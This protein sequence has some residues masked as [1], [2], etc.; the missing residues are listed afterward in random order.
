MP[1][2]LFIAYVPVFNGPIASDLLEFFCMCARR[3]QSACHQYT[4]AG[5]CIFG[6]FSEFRIQNM[7]STLYV[8]F[9]SIFRNMLPH[10]LMHVSENRLKILKLYR[11]VP[12][13][14][15]SV[16]V[17]EKTICGSAT[18]SITFVHSLR[19]RPMSCSSLCSRHSDEPYLWQRH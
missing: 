7:H 19:R 15:R 16:L 12:R 18:D 4:G 2:Y 3:A 9:Q 1:V 17:G 10:I 11:I 14:F 13:P 5:I 8:Y 6:Q